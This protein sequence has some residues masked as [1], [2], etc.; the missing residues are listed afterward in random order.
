MALPQ[1]LG[2]LPHYFPPA[3]VISKKDLTLPDFQK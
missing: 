3:S 1:F 2:F